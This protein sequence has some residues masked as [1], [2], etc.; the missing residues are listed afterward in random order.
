MG[1]DYFVIQE[2]EI[3]IKKVGCTQVILYGMEMIQYML[4]I[5]NIIDVGVTL[6]FYVIM[7]KPATH[8]NMAHSFAMNF[9]SFPATQ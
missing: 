5:N 9:L 8:F 7:H 6:L 4:F 2:V 1:N 3:D